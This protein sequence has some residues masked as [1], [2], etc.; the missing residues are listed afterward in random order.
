[1]NPANAGFHVNPVRGLALS[2]PLCVYNTTTKEISYVSSS[3]RYKQEIEILTDTS[4]ILSLEPVQYKSI[5]DDPITGKTYIGFLAEQ[6]YSVNPYFSWLNEDSTPEGLDHLAILTCV[7]GELKKLR[8]D[9][10]EYRIS[11]P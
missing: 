8:K 1:M 6:A 7:V 3:Q 9:F 5:Y 4:S 11:H 10:D 2:S